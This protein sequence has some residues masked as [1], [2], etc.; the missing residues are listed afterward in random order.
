MPSE[1]HG[2]HHAALWVARIALLGAI[3]LCCAR[4]PTQEATHKHGAV[5]GTVSVVSTSQEPSTSEGLIL[6]L[7]P[8]AEGA[9]SLSAVTDASGNYEFDDLADGDYVLG[10][11]AEG[12]EP[13]TATIRLRGGASVIQNISLKL[14]VVTQR[15]EVTEQAEPLSADSPEDSKLSEKQLAALPLAEE[16]SRRRCL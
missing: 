13:F 14:A 1:T 7:K 12:F 3:L 2:F 8:L 16:T 6:E 10:L 11:R 15:I 4:L 5:R 9:A